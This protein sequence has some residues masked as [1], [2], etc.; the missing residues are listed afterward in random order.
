VVAETRAI[1]DEAIQR[2]GTIEPHGVAYDWVGGRHIDLFN[3]SQPKR[4]N[5]PLP[6][7]MSQ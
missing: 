1:L 7:G 4:I 6:E 2:G 5:F 3:P